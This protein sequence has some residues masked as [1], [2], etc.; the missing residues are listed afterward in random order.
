MFQDLP[1]FEDIPSIQMEKA[2]G[3]AKS[4]A[5]YGEKYFLRIVL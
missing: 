1:V 3:L 4:L 5:V 2:P